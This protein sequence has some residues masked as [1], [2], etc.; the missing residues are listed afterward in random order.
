MVPALQASLDSLEFPHQALAAILEQAVTVA[1]EHQAHRANQ[2]FLLLAS[3]VIQAIL[4]SQ[5]QAAIRVSAPA[6]HQVNQAFPQLELAAIAEFQEILAIQVSV[7]LELAA[8]L[9]H[10]PL[11]SLVIQV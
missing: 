9:E 7:Y 6:A 10:L 5:A 2:V 4:A 11:A 1:L 3:Q 8:S